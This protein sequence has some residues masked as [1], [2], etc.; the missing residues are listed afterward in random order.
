A[1]LLLQALGYGG[2]P[3][4]AILYKSTREWIEENCCV[5]PWLTLTHHGDVAGTDAF[6]DVRALFVVGR[7]LPPPEILARAAEALAR[8]FIAK[9]DYVERKA[10]IPIEPD[11]AGNNAIEVETWRHPNALVERLRRQVTEGALI[12]AA[13]RARAGLRS[14]TEPLDIHL[15]TD[16]PLPELG[17]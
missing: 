5:P 16:V 2:E 9:R 8:D 7:P 11:N 3:V 12:Q 14:P 6:K 17:P 4:A 13:G 10:M 1:A 15:W